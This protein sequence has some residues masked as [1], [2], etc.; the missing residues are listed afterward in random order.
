MA[1]IRNALRTS[2]AVTAFAALSTIASADVLS[3]EIEGLR[4]P[5]GALLV[6]IYSDENAFPA[7]W[8]R[9]IETGRLD[10][11]SAVATIRFENLPPGRYAVA[12]LH[13]EDGDLAMT[14][15]LLGYPLEG[16]GLSNNPRIF[17]PPNFAS[18]AFDLAGELTLR[19]EMRYF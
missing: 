6:A 13:D 19:I 7:D 17:G 15:N 18:A 14:R 8:S 12:V 2:A 16:I 9:A 3:V 11:S 5:T 1:S 10:V 4:T